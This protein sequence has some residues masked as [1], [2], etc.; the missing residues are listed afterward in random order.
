MLCAF[1]SGY[2]NI[3]SGLEMSLTQRGRRKNLSIWSVSHS[4]RSYCYHQQAV[5]LVKV[6]PAPQAKHSQ[7]LLDSSFRLMFP[8]FLWISSFDLY[9]KHYC[10]GLYLSEKKGL[11]QPGKRCIFYCLI[12]FILNSTSTAVMQATVCLAANTSTQQKNSKVLI[13]LPVVF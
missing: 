11:Q 7:G 8:P 3:F 9:M 6:L 4:D 2:L 13:V 1:K 5:R 10:L 12:L